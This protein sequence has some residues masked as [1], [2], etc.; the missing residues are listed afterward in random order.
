MVWA[1]GNNG[2]VPYGQMVVDGRSKWSA[3]TREKR[4]C[5]MDGVQLALGNRGM[6]VEAVRSLRERWERVSRR[7]DRRAVP[8]FFRTALRA[9][10]VITWRGV[11]CRYMMR[12]GWTV[13]RGQLLKIKRVSSMWV[14]GCMLMIVCVLS[15][16]TWLPLLSGGRKSWYIFIIIMLYMVLWSI[17]VL[18]M[19]LTLL[20]VL[21][22]SPV[23]KYLH[24][25]ERPVF[26]G[27]PG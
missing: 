16:L 6:T 14:K 12:L 23:C 25:Q 11:G 4:F 24:E 26:L 10:V 20:Y 27:E 21:F 2:W 13:K 17:F 9:L 15:E 19:Q 7:K 8:M 18:I 22:K 3:F 1:C 5:R